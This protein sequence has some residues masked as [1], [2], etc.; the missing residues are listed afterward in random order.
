M[1]SEEHA[2]H[3]QDAIA[4][5][6]NSTLLMGGIG[7]FVSAIQN[8]LH[9]QNIGPMKVFTRSGTTV[10][11]FGTDD[12]HLSST[13]KKLIVLTAG[14]GGS[15]SFAKAASANL[16]E[17]DDWVNPTIGGLFAGMVLGLR[18]Q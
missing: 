17:K 10:A 9:R 1:A 15:Y 4:I 8:T 2:Y 7:T 13:S 14:M 11:V 6:T 3:A 12:A 16:R 18:C 5:G